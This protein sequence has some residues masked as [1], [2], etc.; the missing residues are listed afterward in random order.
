MDRVEA[1]LV[2]DDDPDVLEAAEFA[3][4]PHCG[5][6]ACALG[7]DDISERLEGRSFDCVLLDMNF[8]AGRRAGADGLAALERIRRSD[9]DVAIVLMTAYGAVALAV[10]GLKLGAADFLLKPWRNEAL[11]AA[12]RRAAVQSRA[13]RTIQ[14]IDMLEREAIRNALDRCGGSIAEAARALGLSRPALYRRLERHGL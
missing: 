2:V 14:P 8:G 1:V 4:A 10:E 5:V 11:L 12:V 6:I 7:P 9:P 3:L 13:A